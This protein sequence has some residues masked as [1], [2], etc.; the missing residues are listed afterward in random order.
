HGH[1]MAGPN[2]ELYGHWDQSW[3]DDPSK[4]R[5]DVYYLLKA[6]E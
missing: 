3:N 4:I 6:E 5:T 1:A 2:W